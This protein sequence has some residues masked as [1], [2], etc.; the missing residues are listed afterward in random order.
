MQA[1]RALALR[2]GPSGRLESRSQHR[3]LRSLGAGCPRQTETSEDEGEPDAAEP[4]PGRIPL[5]IGGN[6]PKG[7]RHAVRYADIWS[8]Y[9]EENAHVD[10]I[11]PR[12]KSLETI[13]AE[14]GRD[15]ATIG[16]SIGV[17]VNPTLPAGA[18]PNVL[19]GSADEIAGA[20]RSFLDVGYTQVELMFNPG[21]LEALE[22]LAPVVELVHNG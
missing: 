10:E 17:L 22:A 18:R 15:P 4:R 7:Q 21:T 3:D 11:A 2:A 13:C 9:V 16:R 12:I 20:L 1:L 14:E 5:L 19:S 6:G 8:A